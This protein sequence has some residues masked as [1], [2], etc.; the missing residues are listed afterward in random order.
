MGCF[1]HSEMKLVVWIFRSKVGM[2]TT[3]LFYFKD[4]KLD[5]KHESFRAEAVLV[6]V[7]DS[8]ITLALWS[9]RR[10]GGIAS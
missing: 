5:L 2:S 7:E 4:G 10:L 8:N 9:Q 1:F 6:W 3:I